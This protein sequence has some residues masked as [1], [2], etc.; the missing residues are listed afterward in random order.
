[1]LLDIG[2]DTGALVVFMP[3]EM[4]EVE[5]EIRPADSPA[6][7]GP[8][9]HVAV[10]SRPSPVGP[11]PSLVYP[12]LTEGRY[13]LYEKGTTEVEMTASVRGGHV[14]EVDWGDA[15]AGPSVDPDEVV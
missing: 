13:E 10:V 14:T 6:G 1:M 4:L 2:G 15:D 11:I 8:F 12:A 9:P 7:S 5:I 3:E